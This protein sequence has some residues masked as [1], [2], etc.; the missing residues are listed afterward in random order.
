MQYIVDVNYALKW[1]IFFV[2]AA[3]VAFS[4]SLDACSN[5]V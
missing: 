4:L 1:T 3:A 5:G 2:A